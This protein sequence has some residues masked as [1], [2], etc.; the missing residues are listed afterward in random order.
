MRISQ[1]EYTSILVARLDGGVD[2]TESDTVTFD[3]LRSV[4]G[5][6]KKLWR[7]HAHAKKRRELLDEYN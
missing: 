5:P 7:G 2:V 1:Q 3:T 4:H 6:E